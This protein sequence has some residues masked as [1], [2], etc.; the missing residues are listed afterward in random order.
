MSDVILHEFGHSPFCIAIAQAL[1]ALG[2][3]FARVEVSTWDRT[4]IA[5]LTGGQYY[6]VPVLVHGDQVVFERSGDSQD[7]ARYV[8]ARFGQGRLFPPGVAGVHE[9]LLEYIEDRVEDLTFKLVDPF[10]VDSIAEVGARTRVVRHKERKFGRGCIETWRR[11]HLALR[12]EA[13]RLLSRLEA[14]LGHRPFLL[15][16]RP[17]YADFSLYGILG[18]LTYRGWNQLAPAQ[19]GLKTWQGRMAGY[20]YA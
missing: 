4:P 12:A 18:N 5:R 14:M 15:G 20:R 19:A 9:I 6:Q 16:E 7:V 3:P 1:E 11:E 2:T 10:Y 17:V 8:E 13:D